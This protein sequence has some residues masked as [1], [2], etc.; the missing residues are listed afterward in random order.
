MNEETLTA[1]QKKKLEELKKTIDFSTI[2]ITEDF[3]FG[4]VMSEPER[5]RAF[6]EQILDLEI[7]HV[8]YLEKQKTVDLALDARS[9]R[10][11]IYVDDGK[12]IYN[13]EMQTTSKRNL[14]KRTRYYQGQ[15]D[16]NLIAKGEDYKKLKKSFIIFI[17]TFD[18]FGKG[19]YIYSF[20]NI[21]KEDQTIHLDDEAYKIFINTKGTVGDVSENF[22]EL[23]DY[24]NDPATASSSRNPL[25][26]E[27]DDAVAK[28]RTS[29]EWRHDY[30]AIKIILDETYQ[31]GYDD[32]IEKGQIKEVLSMVEDEFISPE[33]GAERLGLSITE[34]KDLMAENGY[35]FPKLRMV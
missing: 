35:V 33:K 22:I 2:T 11:D 6:L 12:T 19:R 13:C 10:M 34:L 15:I 16:M 31:D 18:P 4:Y 21:C 24:F 7:D 17:C 1:G 3:M 20:E 25:I 5:C 29:E 27:L 14:P 30:M 8:E 9:I 23:M 26:R 28:A 32:G